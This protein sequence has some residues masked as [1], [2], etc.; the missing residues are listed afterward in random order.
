M[1]KWKTDGYP[2]GT[3]AGPFGGPGPPFWAW[4][5][6]IWDRLGLGLAHLGPIGH[7]GRAHVGPIGFWARV[8]SDQLGS[9]SEFYRRAFMNVLG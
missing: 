2:I 9:I 1:A 5:Q 6:P 8:H 4:A 7:G 3:G